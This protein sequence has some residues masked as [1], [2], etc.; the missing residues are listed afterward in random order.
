MKDYC[1]R[2][3]KEKYGTSRRKPVLSN[4]L[5]LCDV[6]GKW[7]RIALQED[8]YYGEYSVLESHI[9]FLGFWLLREL[10][11]FIWRRIQWLYHWH[12]EKKQK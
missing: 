1:M 7:K 12:I 9:A 6:C 5:G 2:C 10:F 11:Y 8:A 4:D 3:W